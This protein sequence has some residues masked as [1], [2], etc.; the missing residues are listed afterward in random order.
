[1][2]AAYCSEEAAWTALETY[3]DELVQVRQIL[4]QDLDNNG[5]IYIPPNLRQT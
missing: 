4:L 3:R 5:R 2:N 1:M